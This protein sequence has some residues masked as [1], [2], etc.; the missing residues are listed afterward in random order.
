MHGVPF[1][2]LSV[3][4]VPPEEKRIEDTMNVGIYE[5][6]RIKVFNNN[7]GEWMVHCHILGHAHNGM[8]T[9]I[10]FLP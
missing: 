2:V 10:H 3:N 7:P 9:V 4:G 6:V 8:M 1:E 5:V